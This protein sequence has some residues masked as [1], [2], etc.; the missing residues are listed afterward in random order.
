[1]PAEPAAGPAAVAAAGGLRPPIARLR[2]AGV[3]LGALAFLAALLVVAR[4]LIAA[5]VP[6][7]RA[8]LEELIR[9]ETGLEVAFTRLSV[10]LGWG[11]PEAVFHGVALGEPGTAALLRAP[12]LVVG[13]DAWRSVRSGHL[14]AG[15]LTLINADIDLSVVPAVRSGGAPG[16][17]PGALA[18]AGRR[19]LAGWRGGR[20]DVEG[21]TL[22]WPA[23]GGGLPLSV[24]VR[25]AD[26]RR[27]GPDW[28]ADAQLLLPDSLGERAHVA[29]RLAGDLA[30]MQSLSGTLTFSGERLALNGW[31]AL[32]RDPRLLG[33]LPRAGSADLNLQADFTAG[34]AVALAGS[35]QAQAL[36]W[37]ARDAPG[38]VLALPRVAADFKA[39]RR[40]EEWR[41]ALGSLDLGDGAAR[42]KA[43]VV[44]DARGARGKLQE[45]PLPALAAVARWYAPQ[46]PLADLCATGTVSV[47]HFDWNAGR[48]AGARLAAGADLRGLALASC[49]QDVALSGLAAQLTATEQGLAGRLSAPAARLVLAGAAPVVLEGLQV[50]AGVTAAI[51]GPQWH[52]DTQDLR[53]RRADA[54]LA[55]RA[56]LSADAPR[57][58]P[59]LDAHLEVADTDARLLATLLGPA[60][61]AVLGPAAAHL[62][63]GQVTSGT[64]ELHGAFGDAPG[65]L[66]A[67]RGGFEL[68]D[69]VLAAH[70]A[71]PP[72]QALAGRLDWEGPRMR[73][74]LTHA[75]SG[76][77]TLAAARAQWDARGAG[78]LRASVRL[79]GSAQEALAWLRANPQLAAYV[80][81]AAYLDLAG[82]TRL[83]VDLLV[84]GGAAHP[85]AARTRISAV[86]DGARL[87]PLA[88]LPPIEALQ[89]TVSFSA[90]RLQGSKLSGEWLG[91]P[92]TLSVGERREA[93]SPGIVILG[94]GLLDV[95]QALLAAGA[96]DTDATLS[97]NAEW[98]A[99]LSLLPGED[100]A[101]MQW[102][103]RADSSLLGIASRL[104]EP[105]AKA[106]GAA[107]PLHLE[108]QGEATAAQLRL[109]LGERLQ[110]VAA[111]VRSGERWRIERGALRLAGEAPALPGTPVLA[112]EGRLSRLDLPAYL[113]LWPQAGRAALLP[114]LEARVAAAELGA[115]ARRY[116]EASVS[117]RAGVQGGELVVQSAQAGATFRWPARVSAARPALVHLDAFDAGRAGDAA[118][119]AGLTEWLGPAVQ[120]TVEDFSWQGR[121]LGRLSAS[122]ASAPGASPVA[123][124][125][126]TGAQQ[127]L[128]GALQCAEVSCSAR[129]SLSSTDLAAT[130]SA[131]GLRPDLAALRARVSGELAWPQGSAAPLATL[132]GH[133]HMQLEEGATRSAAEDDSRVPFAL[134]LVP[135]LLEGMSADVPAR[136]VADL[137]FARLTADYELRD[138]SASTANLH[139]DGDAEILVH[140]RVGL[141]AHDYEGEAFV[142]KG[143]ERL[144]SAVRRFGPTP[145]V[146]ALWLSLRQWFTGSGAE[147]A[148]AALR[149]RGTWDDPIVLPAE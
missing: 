53:V 31:R 12:L 49:A 96:D 127:E 21:G 77:L 82:D 90:G 128:R 20:I 51:E 111:L 104:P 131:Y 144:P 67:S 48:A 79:T 23:V 129:F 102:R 35:V 148:R 8:A 55:G 135:A 72:V 134:W 93:G 6:Q 7:H 99:R 108:A 112:I 84:P 89:G 88:G 113:A 27:L 106:A 9:H 118:L 110:G 132:S 22:R 136:A 114:T 123:D 101:Q 42:G 30:V 71:W 28:A 115:G 95:H 109:N 50:D 97:G 76:N 87:R 18:A 38:E 37:A 16:A 26:L 126:L 25:H 63:G 41:V 124:L 62:A 145:K 65:V 80:P 59:R 19:V 143:E 57:A 149:L 44:L 29:L 146:A 1:M 73:A 3:L 66:A 117:G 61:S 105:L 17:A 36:E 34:A 47:A 138:G 75:R 39:A 140:G 54:S 94:R 103:V 64:L 121:P 83:D 2:L 45:L 33:W 58:R 43:S 70:E 86:L 142:L 133:L 13:L 78:V 130:L 60:A 139:L 4:E 91:G 100:P 125:R 32:L 120:L 141:L 147:N 122:L 52:L 74:T 14:E 40:G 119:A 107:V 11:G 92:V 81:G 24:S 5:Q 98:S 15:R 10:R 68:K 85:P 46:L 116:P 69:G 137:H 56:R